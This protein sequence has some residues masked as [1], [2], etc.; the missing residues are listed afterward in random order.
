[1]AT[2]QMS[3]RIDEKLK[4]Q[5]DAVFARYGFTPSQAVQ[6]IWAYVASRQSVPE[7]LVHRSCAAR[8]AEKQRKQ[9]LTCDTVYP[10]AGWQGVLV[11]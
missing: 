9:V 2:V 10:C 5:G 7:F 8:L 4:A 11:A 6:A 1:M 3:I